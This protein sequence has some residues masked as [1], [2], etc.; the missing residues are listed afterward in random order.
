MTSQRRSRS[1][2]LRRVTATLDWLH[3]CTRV[4]ACRGARGHS[5]ARMHACAG[6]E[7]QG[8]P[9]LTG[10]A[11]ATPPAPHPPPQ[12]ITQCGALAGLALAAPGRSPEPQGGAGVEAGD[13]GWRWPAVVGSIFMHLPPPGHPLHL[14]PAVGALLPCTMLAMVLMA[15]HTAA[16]CCQVLAAVICHPAGVMGWVRHCFRSCIAGIVVHM[17]SSC[18][19][20]QPTPT[21]TAW[22]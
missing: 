3:R 2:L 12:V 16:L 17:P 15:P 4:H 7:P 14:P 9:T 1:R 5:S 8:Q 22:A 19:L 13:R 6:P 10:L 11:M 20:V 18:L 21:R